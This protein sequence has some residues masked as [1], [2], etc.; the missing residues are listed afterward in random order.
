MGQIVLSLALVSN[1]Y[2]D[3]ADLGYGGPGPVDP[4]ALNG[5]SVLSTE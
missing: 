5:E 2:Y 1:W 3:D 4:M